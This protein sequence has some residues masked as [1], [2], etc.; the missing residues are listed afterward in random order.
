M[1]SAPD[2]LLILGVRHP[3]RR[4]PQLVDEYVDGPVDKIFHESPENE[5][6]AIRYIVWMAIRHPLGIIV[7]FLRLLKFHTSNLRFVLKQVVAG[8]ADRLTWNSDGGAQGRRAARKL[9][10]KHNI[11]WKAVDMDRVERIQH[12]PVYMSLISWIVV[13]F[14]IISFFVM[15]RLTA[16]GLILMLGTI[17]FVVGVSREIA[18]KRRPARDKRMFDNIVKACD[19]KDRAVLITG[20]NH[21]RGIAIR[22][23]A[24][25]ID[26]DG[27]WLS[28]TADIEA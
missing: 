15:V 8:N 9:A 11:D 16:A 17:G 25:E 19:Q 7:G 4:I 10:N 13:A 26:Y 24:F 3:D 1:T 22:A 5:S 6:A 28:S 20:E 2:H 27:Y 14:G 18:D 23:D 12:Q 21:V